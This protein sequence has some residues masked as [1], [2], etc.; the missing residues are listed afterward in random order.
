MSPETQTQPSEQGATATT[1]DTGN[2]NSIICIVLAIAGTLTFSIMTIIAIVWSAFIV[3]KTKGVRGIGPLCFSVAMLL[4][5]V[6]L[7]LSVRRY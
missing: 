5:G 6:V 2:G 7:R 1:P 3:A 4:L